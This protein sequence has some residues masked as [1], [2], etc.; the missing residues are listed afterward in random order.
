MSTTTLADIGPV[1]E[2][3]RQKR[4]DS[5]KQRLL[6]CSDGG[7]FKHAIDKQYGGLGNSFVELISAHEVLGQQTRDP[8]LILAINA[9]LWGAVFQIQRFGTDAQKKTWL[10]ALLD[11]E[12]LSGHAITEPDAGSNVSA[13]TANFKNTADGFIV[14]GHKR[15][16]T[17][18]PIASM[19]VVYAKQYGGDQTCAF[20]IKSTD[21]GVK[22]KDTPCVKGCDT[23]SMGDIVLSDC[24][25]SP[26]R[27]LGKPG[28]GNT[29]IQLS[30]EL[31]RAFIFAGVTGVMQ[32]QLQNAINYARTRNAENGKLAQHQA[33]SH[34]IAQ[35]K[36]RLDTSKL[37]IKHCAELV[38]AGKRIT[39]ASAQTKLYASEAFLQSSLDA[40]QISGAPG[41][42]DELTSLVNDAMA[43]RLMSGSSE[44]QKNIIA[45]MLGVSAKN[46]A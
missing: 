23:A 17:N 24:F 18:T 39:S 28:A 41:L 32:W 15:Y 12:I 9:H 2:S 1:T 44:I 29:M 22:F 27:L 14:N 33:I 16:I 45:A 42:N 13:M 40:V 25:I 19:M 43:G 36:L 46:N 20:M 4:A 7:F 37:W 31:E 11:G 10:P 30:L 3:D 21:P 35:M 34:K 5:S 6:A 26:S 8:G 38:D